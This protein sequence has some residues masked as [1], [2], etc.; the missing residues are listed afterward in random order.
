MS[1][2]RVAIF[3][4]FLLVIPL[5]LIAFSSAQDRVGCCAETTNGLEERSLKILK[6]K[7][8]STRKNLLLY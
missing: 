6:N 1:K 2:K 7:E 5:F 4:A 3:I 8:F